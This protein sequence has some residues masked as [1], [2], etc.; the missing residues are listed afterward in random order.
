[1]LTSKK[2]NVLW[3]FSDQ[4]RYHAL[5]CNGDPNVR[6]PNIDRLAAEVARLPTADHTTLVCCAFLLETW[7]GRLGI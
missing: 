4:L 5:S 6:T 2:S 3:I 7:P 1:M